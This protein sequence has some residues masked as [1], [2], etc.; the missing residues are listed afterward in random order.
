[1]SFLITF[2]LAIVLMMTSVTGKK[3]CLVT[4]AN[5]GIGKEIARK[6]VENDCTVLLGCRNAELGRSAAVELGKDAH[7]VRLDL[8][9]LSSILAAQETIQREYGRLDVLVNNAAIA[10]KGSD[11]TPFQQQSSP[12]IKINF[13]GTLEVTKT[14]MDLLKK[15]TDPRIVNVASMAGH[16]DILP[17]KGRR[18]VFESASTSLTVPQL[19]SLMHEFV[20]DVENGRHS[21]K[22]WPNSNYGMSKLG[23]I[24]LTKI[25]ARDE[26]T[27]MVNACCPGYCDTDM[28]SHRGTK[29][30]E[31]GARTPAL[32][33][34]TPDRISGAFYQEE[35]PIKW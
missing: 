4:G 32:L 28:T 19:E 27:L 11:P 35:K 21:Q 13:F 20:D 22:G 10:Y 17:S 5:K 31:Q 15:S 9:D 33:A 14:M 24:A 16:L 26:P 30:A 18:A 7:F 25:L 34:L 12:T 6:L 23:V 8:A 3:I 29:T 1:M 2:C